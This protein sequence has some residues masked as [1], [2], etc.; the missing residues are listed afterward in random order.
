MRRS[1]ITEW[2]NVGLDLLQ[3]CKTKPKTPHLPQNHQYLP[4]R[5]SNR[6]RLPS[7]SMCWIFMSTE[8][9]CFSSSAVVV[10][11]DVVV[12][13]SVSEQLSIMDSLSSRQDLLSSHEHVVGVGVLLQEQRV[14][15]DI[16]N[17]DSEWQA[18][19]IYIHQVWQHVPRCWGQAWCR[20]ASQPVDICPAHRSQ[21]HTT[22]NIK[23]GFI[24]MGH[25]TPLNLCN[26]Y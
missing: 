9:S 21:C 23:E 17:M 16:D 25:V 19:C 7:I 26:N 3:V 14:G 24:N 20:T 1:S 12:R 13:C 11:T 10:F 2:V 8:A 6:L 15:I 4:Q 5:W 22:I 18:L